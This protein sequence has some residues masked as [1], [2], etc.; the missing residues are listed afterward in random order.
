[1]KPIPGISGKL[2]WV[3]SATKNAN[4]IFALVGNARDENTGAV[5][6]TART[7]R[8]GQNMGE[9][10]ATSWASEIEITMCLLLCD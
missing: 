2:A 10:H 3:A 8:K 4:A 9:I 5:V 1:L 6:K 7:R